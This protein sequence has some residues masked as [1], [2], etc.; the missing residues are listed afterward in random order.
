MSKEEMEINLAGIRVV[1]IGDKHELPML[2]F[3]VKKFDVNVRDWSTAMTADSRVD[4]FINVFNFSKSAWEPL[5]EP[6][7]L[8]FHLAKEQ[9]PEKL[10]LDL[11]SRKPMELTLTEATIAMAS[12]SIDFLSTDDD[13]LSKPRRI[14]SP[15]RIRNHTGFTMDVWAASETAGDG[16]AEKLEDGVEVSWRFEDAMTTRETLT[17]EGATGVVGVKLE[18]SGFDSIAKISVSGEGES[19]YN[20]R[21]KKN[22]VQH[23][24]LVEV[25]LGTDNV[26]YITFRSPLLVENNTQIPVEIGV[27][28]PEEGHIL[29]I[30]KIQPGDARPAPV[31]AAYKHSLIVRPDQGFGYSWS[32]DRL[33][34]KDL[35]QRP[36]R[37]LTCRGEQ[38]DQ[39]PPVYFQMF[40]SFNKKDP[41]T[42]VYPYMRIRLHAPVEIHNLLP[43]DFKYRIFDHNTKKDWTNFLRRGGI[44]P[45]HVVEL[46]H[47]LMMSIDLQH[48]A[49]KTSE[50]A[51]ISSSDRETYRREKDVEV[52]DKGGLSLRLKL[53]YL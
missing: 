26:K 12:K 17:P 28:S 38:D 45:V 40:A 37:T 9:H 29:K 39:S 43:Y 5:I 53:H 52:K 42:G 25:K 2:D 51:V 27:F 49:F 13:V 44:S 46:T 6:W 18:G 41:L 50:F 22:G 19:L 21:P 8:G 47:L 20:L 30:E 15:F 3:S 7:H 33:F 32:S 16:S 23:R 36:T 4:T 31:G 34:W 48:E 24:L 35:L 1:L 14:E 10:S 11:Y